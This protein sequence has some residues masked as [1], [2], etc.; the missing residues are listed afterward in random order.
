MDTKQLMHYKFWLACGAIIVIELGL[1]AFYPLTNDNGET[2]EE[3]KNKLD[4]DYKKLEDLYE[5]AGREPKGVFDAEDPKDIDNLTKLYLLTPRWK[6]VLQPHVDK[7]NQ[8]LTAIKQDLVTRSKVLHEPIADSGDLF[9]WYTTYAGK[10]KELLIALRNAQAIV[11]APD[12]KED[13]DFENG[14]AIRARVGFFTK[15]EKTPE[16][17]EHAQL[18]TRFRIIEKIAQAVIKNASSSVANPIVKV[19]KESELEQKKCAIFTSVEW[20]Q[21]SDSNEVLANDVG[22][23]AGAYEF[24]VT[25]EGSTSTLIATE[26]AIERIAEP[27]MVVVGS[28]LSARGAQ[29]AASR[30]N[31]ADEPMIMRITVAVLDFSKITAANS[32]GADVSTGLKEPAESAPPTPPAK[33]TEGSEQ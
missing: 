7:Y 9:S 16:A 22:Q 15:V 10:T 28:T 8:Q 5:R 23:Y 12:N 27:V 21:S 1:I 29:P 17:K 2:P 20:K 18:T 24:T 25:L 6:N 11:I 33:E 19:G 3:V 14:A 30:K 13:N 31:I 4:Q 32:V 26:A